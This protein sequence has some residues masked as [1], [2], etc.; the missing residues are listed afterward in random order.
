MQLVYHRGRT[1]NLGDDLNAAIWPALAPALFDDDDLADGLAGI[2]AVI[3]LPVNSIRVLHVFSSGAGNNRMENWAGQNVCYWCVRGPISARLAGVVEALAIT[4]GAILTP[5]VKGYPNAATGYRGVAVVPHWETLGHPGWD[6]VA[7]QTGFDVIDPRGDPLA[8]VQRIADARLVLAESLHGAIIADT[9]GIPWA[10]FAT[11]KD[12][13]CVEWVDWTMSLG[14]RFG[15]TMVP[16]PSAGPVT[17]FGRSEGDYGKRIEMGADEAMRDF[18]ERV[19]IVLSEPPLTLKGHAK[20]AVRQTRWLHPL[21]GFNPSRT[22]AALS[23]LAM[24]DPCLSSDAVRLR[25]RDRMLERL[26][27]MTAAHRQ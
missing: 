19:R 2:G 4:D 20:R 8:I 22:A 3:G 26:A 16:P 7:K 23:A 15:M 21:L 27:S 18:H 13:G 12:F 6:A 1:L 17:A 14:M 25:L 9:Y 11:S 24:A 5:L 10:A